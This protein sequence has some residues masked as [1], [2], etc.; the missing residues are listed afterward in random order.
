MDYDSVIAYIKY[1]L[2]AY[3]DEPSKM[4]KTYSDL[5]QNVQDA[6]NEYG[7]Q[8]MSPNYE[9][10]PEA[11]KLVPKERWYVAHAKKPDET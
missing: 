10:D 7:V 8:I 5:H 9:A 4:F 3:T 2:N 11:P 6:F 1:E